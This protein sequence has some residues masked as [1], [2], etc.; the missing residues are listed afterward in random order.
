[1]VM[2]QPTRRWTVVSVV[3]LLPVLGSCAALGTPS[4]QWALPPFTGER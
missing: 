2:N 4:D 3:L 1:M